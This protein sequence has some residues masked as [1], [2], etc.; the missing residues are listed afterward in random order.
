MKSIL[1][2]IISLII[3]IA[4]IAQQKEATVIVYADSAYTEYV[5]VAEQW[6]AAYNG[7]D[8]NKLVD[9]YLEDAKYIS[10]H[11]PGLVANGRDR[12]I[13][14]FQTGMKMGGHLEDLEILS[15]TQSCDLATVL[16][17]YNA[18][19]AGEKVSG[20]T[21]LVLKK[22]EGKWLIALHMTVV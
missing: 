11:V 5:Q 18:N 2:F 3:S 7:T 22:V 1:V 15:I 10:G 13:A 12:L 9:L 17:E 20:R 8:A 19:N 21:L 16:C 4:S 6:I 14:N